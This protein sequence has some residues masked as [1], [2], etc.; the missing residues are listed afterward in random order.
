MSLM[1]R[2]HSGAFDEIA[3]VTHTAVPMIERLSL[4]EYADDK[5]DFSHLI[6]LSTS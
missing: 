5:S 1:D 3:T 4:F 2:L 6:H